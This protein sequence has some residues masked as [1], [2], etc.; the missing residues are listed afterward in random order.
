MREGY[1]PARV[2]PGAAPTVG[3][4]PPAPHPDLL[5]YRHLLVFSQLAEDVQLEANLGSEPARPSSMEP[6]AYLCGS[7]RLIITSEAGA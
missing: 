4:R 2:P 5:A 6:R 1:A 3:C 7:L